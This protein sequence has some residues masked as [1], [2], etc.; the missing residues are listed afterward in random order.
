[1]MARHR[2]NHISIAYAPGKAEAARA[3]AT[4]AAMLNALGMEVHLCG[5]S[6]RAG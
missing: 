6:E 2:A 5:V 1:M 3:L 4:K